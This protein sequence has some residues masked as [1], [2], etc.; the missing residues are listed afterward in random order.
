MK[1]EPGIP[2]QSNTKKLNVVKVE[3]NTPKQQ[4]EA[5]TQKEKQTLI[6]KVVS[7]KS[8]NQQLLLQLKNEQ[9]EKSS[10]KSKLQATE[11]KIKT[12]SVKIADL[13]CAKDL[14]EARIK[15]LKR[16]V[17]SKTH[18]KEQGESDDD[19][20]YEVEKLMDHK[21]ENGVRYYLVR[22]K[23]YTQQDDTWEKES[24]FYCPDI[25]N[26]YNASISNK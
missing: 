5:A 17:D 16:G 10:L 4:N 23:G 14:L 15:Q 9:T 19:D 7:L 24:N 13:I 26:A 22:W 25:L 20:V 12:Q 2:T 18:S 21:M 1:T 3:L 11:Q 6:E 8:E